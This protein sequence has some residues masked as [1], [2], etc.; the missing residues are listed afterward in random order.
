MKVGG[1]SIF[2]TMDQRSL[3]VFPEKSK[4][5]LSGFCPVC[6]NEINSVIKDSIGNSKIV[7]RMSLDFYQNISKFFI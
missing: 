6:L 2:L 7:L 4:L 1:L 3:E 5:V